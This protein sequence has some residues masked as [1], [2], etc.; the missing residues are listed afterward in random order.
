MKIGFSGLISTGK[1]TLAK[2]VARELGWHIVPEG[3]P[4]ELY[5]STRERAADILRQHAQTKRAAQSAYDDCVLDRTAVDLAMLILNQFELLNLPAT[6]RAFAECQAM[7]RELD[8]LFLLPEDAIPFDSAANEAGLLRQYNPLMRTRSSILLNGL[9]ERLMSREA[10]VRVPVTVTDID[11]RV[12]FVISKVQTH[13]A[14][15][16]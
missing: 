15:Q 8:L 16:D 3:I 10:L 6:Q 2:A 13:Q 4:G 5:K 1:T 14:E 7:A 9:A 11:E 12:A